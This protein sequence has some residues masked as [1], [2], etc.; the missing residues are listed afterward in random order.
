MD[1][2]TGL[3]KKQKIVLTALLGVA[4]FAP[5]LLSTNSRFFWIPTWL[6]AVIAFVGLIGALLVF[7]QAG[8]LRTRFLV[9]FFVGVGVAAACGALLGHT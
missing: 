8:A 9:L 3:S 4:V 6:G 7:W 1:R 2:T 5:V